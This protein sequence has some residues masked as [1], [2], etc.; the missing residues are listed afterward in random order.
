MNLLHRLYVCQNCFR[1]YRVSF[2]CNDTIIN[3]TP[4]P[5]GFSLKRLM[6]INEPQLLLNCKC[7]MGTKWQ[8][9][10][11]KDKETLEKEKKERVAI[12][13]DWPDDDLL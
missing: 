10:S 4:K 9:L 13:A 2:D 3:I 12:K 5:L 1:E 11:P 8:M 7:L 6:N